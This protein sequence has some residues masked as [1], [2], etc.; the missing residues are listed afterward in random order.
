MTPQDLRWQGDWK[1]IG[2]N[3]FD[4]MSILR[5]QCDGCCEFMM[6]LVDSGVEERTVEETV[7]VIEERLSQKDAQN[8]VT[9][10]FGQ[11]WQRGLN[12]K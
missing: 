8:E 3:V 10:E 4:G 1:R 12:S 5:C 7:T 2:H 9:K 11:G 6:P